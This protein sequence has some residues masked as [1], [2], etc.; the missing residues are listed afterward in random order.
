MRWL[1]WSIGTSMTESKREQVF[2]GLGVSGG[3]AIGP[4]HLL[5]E[6]TAARRSFTTVEEEARSFRE[7][8]AA[9]AS[10][11]EALIASQDKLA[12]EILEFQLALLDDEDMLA[13]VFRS[14]EGGTPWDE[15]WSAM[16]SRE[17]AEYA[18]SGGGTLAARAGDL[19]DLQGR[20][21]R[22]PHGATT[23]RET[24]PP[25][26]ILV[27]ADL[28]PSIFV[29][30]DWEAIAGAVTLGG[31]PVSHVS[32]LARARG[33]N[34]MV[35]LN[36]KLEEIGQGD[37]AI[38]DA[39][40]GLLTLHPSSRTL[41]SANVRIDVER[42]DRSEMEALLPRPAAAAGGEPVKIMVNIDEP[43]RLD[44]LSPDHCD[45]V[46]LTRTEFL[47]TA[48][49]LPGEDEQLA[50]YRRLITWAAGRPVTIRTLD[51]GGDKPIPGVTIDGEANPFL[52]VRG[53]R[54]SFARPEIF[55]VQL[56]ALARAAADGPLNVMFPMVT[57]PAEFA[58]ARRMML[59][60]IADLQRAGVDC[61]VPRMGIMVEVP[62]AALTAADFDAD[63]YS[64]GSNDLIQYAT[65]CARDNSS[66]APLAD[67]TNPAV[68]EL[69]RRTVEAARRRGVEV[70]LCG[71]MASSPQLIGA[72]LDTGLR[73]L[74]CAPAQIGPVKLA[75]SRYAPKPA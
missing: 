43:G 30:L 39:A 2:R 32:I 42:E 68:M 23:L 7:A 53:L 4:I 24:I 17:I 9:A 69:I 27:A 10:Q 41:A 34:F 50:F 15:A 12:G 1:R 70:S 8:V 25:G 58:E 74:S 57:V 19:A 37:E 18:Q 59:A 26:S 11:L 66:L 60:E 72:L 35:G 47:F 49:H 20:V 51:A 46:G 63:F 65:A 64:I 62:A 3:V 33:I 54:L 40:Q 38:L 22:A 44:A 36:A 67:P 16:L 61:A 52:G 55:R 5:N 56:R 48:G 45:G 75:V 31:S 14:I 29:D 13:P 21:V 73:T 71:D 28:T 6:T